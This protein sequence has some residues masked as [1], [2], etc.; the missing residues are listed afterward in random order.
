M[1]RTLLLVL[2]AAGCTLAPA[3]WAQDKPGRGFLK[4]EGQ[5]AELKAKPAKDAAAR[6]R[7]LYGQRVLYKASPVKGWVLVKE[8]G[9]SAQGYFP[10]AMISETRPPALQVGTIRGRVS[11]TGA[12]G[13]E[14]IST[15][16][17]RS[18]DNRAKQYAKAKGGDNVE[19]VIADVASL[20][21]LVDGKPSEKIKGL[22]PDKATREKKAKAFKGGNT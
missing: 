3:A 10:Q 15:A 8:A 11:D 9:G 17:V 4:P 21:A 14:N 22:Y 18:L 7:L 1:M 5:Y 19:Q 12:G 6:A 13:A 16:A 20:E 2:I